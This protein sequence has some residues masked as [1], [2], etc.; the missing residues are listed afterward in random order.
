MSS[1]IPSL[2]YSPIVS[3]NFERN[4]NRRLLLL[5]RLNEVIEH[6]L[7]SYR[8]EI[9]S[10]QHF[11]LFLS[12]HLPIFI[13]I[14]GNSN[15]YFSNFVPC[16]AEQMAFSEQNLLF[17]MNSFSLTVYAQRTVSVMRLWTETENSIELFWS[18]SQ[19]FYVKCGCKISGLHSQINFCWVWIVVKGEWQ[20]QRLRRVQ[21]NFPTSHHSCPVVLLDSSLM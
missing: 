8:S 12:V 20:R 18:D 5:R 2:G 7:W 16:I 21:W 15:L 14:Y 10:T 11:S 1:C 13:N 6:W 3:I 4:C 9:G 19:F 17:D